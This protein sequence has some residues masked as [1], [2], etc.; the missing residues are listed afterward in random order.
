M[1]VRIAKKK[2]KKKSV[3]STQLKLKIQP[4]N[5]NRQ[6]PVSK[7]AASQRKPSHSTHHISP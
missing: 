1:T 2:K 3:L 6:I 5:I 4:N 7:R